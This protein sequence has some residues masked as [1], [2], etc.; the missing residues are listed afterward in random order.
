MAVSRV[1]I[2]AKSVDSVTCLIKT[3]VACAEIGIS[4]IITSGDAIGPVITFRAIKT[5]LTGSG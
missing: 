3:E 2:K 4:A 5:N 1:L